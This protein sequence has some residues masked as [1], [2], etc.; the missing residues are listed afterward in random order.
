[1]QSTGH[2]AT[3]AVS[4][5]PMQGWAIMW[6]MFSKTPCDRRPVKRG[7]DYRL[8]GSR[9]KKKAGGSQGG[10]G[11]ESRQVVGALNAGFGGSYLSHEEGDLQSLPGDR[12]GGDGMAGDAQGQQLAGW[13]IG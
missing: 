5:V 9:G 8:R 1:M 11:G 2:T 4:F 10:F 12:L 13:V 7:G 6:A 3:Q